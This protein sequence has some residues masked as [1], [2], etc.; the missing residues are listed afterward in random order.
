MFALK[1]KKKEENDSRKWR[2]KYID[3]DLSSSIR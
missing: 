3:F 1:K 2:L